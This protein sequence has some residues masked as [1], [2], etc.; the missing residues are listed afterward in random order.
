MQLV[1]GVYIGSGFMA[2]T[3]ILRLTTIDGAYHLQGAMTTKGVKKGGCGKEWRRGFWDRLAKRPWGVDSSG[4]S[5]VIY[6]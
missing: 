4:M 2:L 3:W 6:K 1:I 5:I